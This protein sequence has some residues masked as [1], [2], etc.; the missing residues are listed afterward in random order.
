MLATFVHDI[1]ESLIDVEHDIVADFDIHAGQ[2]NDSSVYRWKELV[3][4][5]RGADRPSVQIPTLKADFDFQN[6]R[7]AKGTLSRTSSCL[8]DPFLLVLKGAVNYSS[9]AGSKLMPACPPSNTDLEDFS[10]CESL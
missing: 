2:T 7:I 4:E 1:A 9:H 8:P 6:I 10:D 5:L 3:K